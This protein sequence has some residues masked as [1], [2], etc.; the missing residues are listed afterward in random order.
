MRLFLR[1]SN[2]VRAPKTSESER[3]LLIYYF[4]S[5]SADGSGTIMVR[6]CALDSGTL[7]TDTELIRMSHCGSF[8]F[9]DKYVTLSLLKKS[10]I[11]KNSAL[12]IRIWMR[13]KLR[14]YR[15]MQ[16]CSRKSTLHFNATHSAT[17]STQTFE[18]GRNLKKKRQTE[19][20]RP[21]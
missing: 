19:S 11:T 13:P 20:E 2:N 17:F 10:S 21:N 9:E 3:H 4:F 7:T 8:Y 5:Y 6:G 14:W 18:L 16:Y 1:F 15:S 12:Q